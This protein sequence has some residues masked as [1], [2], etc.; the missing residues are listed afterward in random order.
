MDLYSRTSTSSAFFCLRFS[1]HHVVYKTIPLWSTYRSNLCP[2]HEEGGKHFAS[3]L[4]TAMPSSDIENYILHSFSSVTCI[5][6][7]SRELAYKKA[8]NLTVLVSTKHLYSLSL[9]GFFPKIYSHIKYSCTIIESSI[10]LKL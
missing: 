2:F 5:L 7:L 3:F 4:K 1:K 10:S 9:I 8:F 6:D